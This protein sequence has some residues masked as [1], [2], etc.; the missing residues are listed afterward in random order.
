MLLR[1]I[2]KIYV[3]LMWGKILTFDVEPSELIYELKIKI[4][5][6]E[7]MLPRLVFAG[8]RL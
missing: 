2:M 8:N 3:K 5:E 7:G 4:L 6:K 1:V